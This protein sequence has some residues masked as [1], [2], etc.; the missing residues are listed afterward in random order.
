VG[1]GGVRRR[2]VAAL[3]G[4]LAELERALRRGGRPAAPA[5][6]LRGLERRFGSDPDAVG[7]LR[8]L[9]DR[10][11]GLAGGGP[12]AAQRRGLR[13]ALARGLGP[14]GRLRALWALPPRSGRRGR[15]P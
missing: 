3:G 14:G 6:T 8:A 2:R 13:R 4:E 15:H 10:R 11:F 5:T 12:S 9:A 7:Y 1:A